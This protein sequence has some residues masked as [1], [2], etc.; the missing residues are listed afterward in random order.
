MCPWSTTVPSEGVA[1]SRW[2]G[3]SL[4]PESKTWGNDT[5]A[6]WRGADGRIWHLKTAG[7]SRCIRDIYVGGKKLHSG[8]GAPARWKAF[9]SALR[10]NLQFSRRG[11]RSWRRLR[12]LASK[13]NLC[14]ATSDSW[15]ECTHNAECCPLGTVAAHIVLLLSSP[16]GYAFDVRLLGF[17][18]PGHKWERL[19]AG[20]GYPIWNPAGF[21]LLDML[22][23]GWPIFAL[24]RELY[25]RVRRICERPVKGVGKLA[26][27]YRTLLGAL[28][29]KM[30]S[31]KKRVGRVDVL[32]GEQHV[33]SRGICLL[34]P[35]PS[36]LLI[37]KLGCPPVVA[38]QLLRR[39]ERI[40]QRARGGFLP[41]KTH[42]AFERAVNK[43][44]DH[45]SNLVLWI[46]EPGS[47]FRAP[48]ARVLILFLIA[49]DVIL[50]Q[51]ER[52]QNLLDKLLLVP[53]K[54]PESGFMC[55]AAE[56]PEQGTLVEETAYITAWHAALMSK[57]D[58]VPSAVHP[59]PFVVRGAIRA[60]EREAWVVFIWGGSG[61][62]A[63]RKALLQAE[64]VRTLGHSV[65]RAEAPLRRPFVV[66]TVGRLP[67]AAEDDLLNDGFRLQMVHENLTVQA[68]EPRFVIRP[69][70]SGDW[71]KERGLAPS[72]AQ[73]AAWSLTEFER[74]VVL[75]ADTLVLQNCDELFRLH[76][77]SFA[78][79]LET[80][81]DQE[82]FT[83]VNP[84]R[85]RTYLIN[86]G[87]ILLKPDMRVID[88]VRK[89]VQDRDGFAFAVE[90]VS[91]HGNPTFQ[92]LIDIFLLDKKRRRGLVRFRPEGDFLGCAPTGRS[93]AMFPSRDGPAGILGASN[94]GG[95]LLELGGM[96]DQDHCLLP[97]EYNFFADFAHAFQLAKHFR[98]TALIDKSQ[99]AHPGVAAAIA[100]DAPRR[101]LLNATADWLH[102]TGV[103]KSQP[104]I[105]HFPGIWRKPWQRMTTIS[106][107]PWDEAWWQ[108]HREMCMTSKAPCRIRCDTA[109]N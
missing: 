94:Q 66:M 33:A 57:R 78:A 28:L 102:R 45:L 56:M 15:A 75:D 25:F 105:I 107:S 92:A 50:P 64:V 46:Q 51:L 14:R 83:H 7:V 89:A 38:E 52:I 30:D 59:L 106:R 12:G 95:S 17:F 39:A 73:I 23:S 101:L 80:H 48:A 54:P 22:Y 11:F 108:A 60:A 109:A 70:H 88:E 90:R 8:V 58:L 3:T 81:R 61:A 6:L 37:R 103:L 21:R 67:A 27:D 18:A 82:D 71:F 40:L 87:V 29:H 68:W 36:E 49:S 84:N 65:R 16:E 77:I 97:L 1:G 41:P 74:V 43:A 19:G 91:P 85:V 35:G 32:F 55:P 5:E 2:G 20:I 53:P 44:E 4:G 99:A 9:A 72:F 63:T 26:T 24:L 79:S 13:H 100:W 69:K 10:T 31:A 93:E 42:A 34:L 104:K 47:W 96:D 98:E 86:A 76:R 62:E